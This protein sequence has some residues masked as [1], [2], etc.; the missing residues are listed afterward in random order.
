VVHEIVA[1]VAVKFT[2]ATFEM[3]GTGT[4]VCVCAAL[5]VNVALAE[6]EDCPAEFADTTSNL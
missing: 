1:D 2:A 3:A 6:V 4:G 5:V